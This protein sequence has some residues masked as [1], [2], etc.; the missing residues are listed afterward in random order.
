MKDSQ[1]SL[2][3]ITVVFNGKK[4]IEK[5]IK[6]IANQNY[7]NCEYIIID[8][9]SN[10]GT[11]EIILKYNDV[12]SDFITEKDKGI[13]DAMNKGI[14]LSNGEWI[15]FINGGDQIN[16]LAFQDCLKE[17]KASTADIVYGNVLIEKNGEL[18]DEKAMPLEIINY[19]QSFCHQSS[20]VRRKLFTD[21]LFNLKYKI[22]ADYHWFLNAYIH[23][24]K[25]Q[26]INYPISIFESGGISFK[27]SFRYFLE[28]LFIVFN[29]H[30]SLMSKIWFSFKVFIRL[31]NYLFSV[32]K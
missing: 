32:I 20:F 27:F 31:K 14:K 16:S 12:V 7:E 22:C 24:A 29:S 6:N 13:Y 18:I 10:D 23:K 19:C 15:I 4:S 5:T 21:N 9:G 17:L 8:G 26:Y 11:Q 1:V 25:F 28:N 3:I 30:I 2:S